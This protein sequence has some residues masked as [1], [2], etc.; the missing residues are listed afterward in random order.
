MSDEAKENDMEEGG[1][2]KLKGIEEPGETDVLCGRGGAAL[3]HPGNQTYRRLVHLNKGLYIT[4]LK[5]EKLK[6][7]RSI[8]AAI[9]EQNGRFLEKEAGGNTWYDI[10]DKKA[11]EKT[12]QALREGQPKLRQKNC[13]ARRWSHWGSCAVGIA[14]SNRCLQREYSRRCCKSATTTNAATDSIATSAAA[15]DTGS[16]TTNSATRNV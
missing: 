14:I 7:S 2:Q 11:M 10:G 9:R 8:V 12:S 13:R 3:R 6:I 5:A 4:C 16:T 1:K 15:T